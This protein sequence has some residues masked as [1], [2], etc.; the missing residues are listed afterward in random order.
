LTHDRRSPA[1]ENGICDLRAAGPAE[2][3]LFA[4]LT[5]FADDEFA[6]TAD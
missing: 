4:R 1:F 5:D 6:A 2:K 3:S